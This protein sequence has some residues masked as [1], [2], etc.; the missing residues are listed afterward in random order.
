MATID[1]FPSQSRPPK[2]SKCDKVDYCG[3]D[4][5]YWTNVME[6]ST[7]GANLNKLCDEGHATLEKV[8][9]MWGPRKM[10]TSQ[11]ILT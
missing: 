3:R 1:S 11:I 9:T 6:L 7:E 8:S 10:V 2:N 5:A 4:L